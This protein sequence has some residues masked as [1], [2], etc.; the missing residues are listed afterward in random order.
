MARTSTVDKRNPFDPVPRPVTT[1][2]RGAAK[3]ET[4]Q[5][6]NVRAYRN[7]GTI[8]QAALVSVDKPLTAQQVAFVQHWARGESISSAALR[9]G[10]ANE[11]VAYRMVHMP[12]IRALYEKEKVLYEAAAQMTRQR[13]MDGLLEG[14]EMAKLMSEPASMISGWREIG[15]MCGYYEPVKH[16]L[17]VNV[18]GE[19]TV[20]QLNALSDAELLKLITAPGPMSPPSLSAP[21]DEDE[22][23]HA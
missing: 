14:I 6:K 7:T 4:V 9:A 10:Y 23:S 2:K 12:N 16:T 8:G 21:G 3:T 22:D 20:R 1:S 13:V 17:D 11:G 18:K 15:K 5:S 19:V